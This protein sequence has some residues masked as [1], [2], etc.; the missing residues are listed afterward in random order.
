MP[1][2]DELLAW[3]RAPLQELATERA[4]T[5]DKPWD[6][7]RAYF[8]ARTGLHDSTEHPL[9]DRLLSRLDELSTDERDAMLDDSGVLEAQV[10]ELATQLAD[11]QG[12]DSQP[13]D[14][15][16]DEGAWQRFLTENGP[17]WSGDE[18]SWGQFSEWFL[19]YANESGVGAPA[20]ALI[21]Y[22]A[23]Q[24]AH[25]RIATLAQYGVQITAPAGQAQP[26]QLTE[27]NIQSL[28][29][30]T[31]DFDDIPEERRRELIQQAAAGL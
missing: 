5:P 25:D 24:A 31:A 6:E 29:D 15:P 17:R 13:A 1:S 16:Y 4:D 22:L 27:E 2:V 20:T 3:L 26:V 23:A 7:L 12:G 30:Q 14:Q 8:L 21:Q 10:Y 28:L 11:P 19:Y 18:E 9:V